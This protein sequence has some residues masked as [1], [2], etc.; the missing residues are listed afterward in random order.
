MDR[1]L[2]RGT[3]WN[4][5]N[6][7]GTWEYREEDAA[8]NGS[9]ISRL[10]CARDFVAASCA[11]FTSGCPERDTVNVNELGRSAARSIPTAK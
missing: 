6:Y 3:R 4:P 1:E 11:S 9:P 2:S 8:G 10:A 5:E 7:T